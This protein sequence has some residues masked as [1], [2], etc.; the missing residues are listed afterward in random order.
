MSLEGDDPHEERGDENETTK[1]SERKRQREKQRRSDLSN[2]FD[3]LAAFIVLVEPET[4]EGDGDSK[5]KRKKSGD[6]EESSGITRLDLIGRALQIMKRLYRE[7]EEQKLIIGRMERGDRGPMNDNVMVMVPQLAPASEEPYP[8]VA[9]A[10]YPSY[11]PNPPHSSY[12]QGIPANPITHHHSPPPHDYSM[13]FA[14]GRSHTQYPA[15][16]WNSYGRAP[17]HPPLGASQMQSHRQN[18]PPD[19]NQPAGEDRR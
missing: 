16:G 4:G 10:S 11:P 2:A 3:E 15:Q 19:S 6:G 12:Y 8:P 9:R 17:H 1:R 14:P 13:H 7:N 5:K 18:Y